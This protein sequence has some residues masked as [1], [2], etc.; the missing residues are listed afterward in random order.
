MYRSFYLIIHRFDNQ[1]YVTTVD[2]RQFLLWNFTYLFGI[3]CIYRLAMAQCALHSGL[4]SSSFESKQVKVS[5]L[6]HI[7]LL[8]VCS[9]K[10]YE[11]YLHKSAS[12]NIDGILQ[13]SYLHRKILKKFYTGLFRNQNND[14]LMLIFLLV[15]TW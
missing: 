12:I 5:S 2:K 15:W 8:K 13:T 6:E 11:I 4:A 1:W 14:N 7:L 9:S 10:N 3:L